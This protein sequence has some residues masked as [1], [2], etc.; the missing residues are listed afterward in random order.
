MHKRISNLKP[1]HM[2]AAALIVSLIVVGGI[3]V[4]ASFKTPAE[5][6]AL[7]QTQLRDKNYRAALKNLTKAAEGGVAESQYTL[8]VM[9]D[10]GDKIPE[11]RDMALKWMQA[12]ADQNHPNALYAMGVWMQRGYLGT[13]QPEDIIGLYERAATQGNINAMT[14]LVALYDDI[15]PDRQAYWYRQLQERKNKNGY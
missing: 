2:I 15:N 12:A 8:A 3:I 1:T 9:Y 13:Y 11:N 5:Y 4:R 10:V 7:A 6:A 14:G